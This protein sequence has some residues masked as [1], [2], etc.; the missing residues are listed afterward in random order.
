MCSVLMPSSE[1]LAKRYGALLRLSASF[2]SRTPEDLACNLARELRSVLNFDCLDV[3]VYKEGSSEVLWRALGDGYTSEHDIPMEETPAWWAYQSQ[4]KLSISDWNRDDRFSSL[5]IALNMRKISARS[6]CIL[7]LTTSQARLGVLVIASEQ[8]HAYSD[9]DVSFLSMV[10][11][12]LALALGDAFCYEASCRRI[13]L[14]HSKPEILHAPLYDEQVSPQLSPDEL[15]PTIEQ[16]ASCGSK[17]TSPG[18]S[19]GRTK[20]NRESQRNHV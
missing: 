11:D 20:L 6:I 15:L 9:E 13:I 3:L 19:R 5:K 12:G 17:G 4:Q 18:F 8:P 16:I 10:A 14:M 2:P 1:V 7:P